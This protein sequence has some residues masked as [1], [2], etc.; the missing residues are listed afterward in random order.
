M[1]NLKKITA[2][3]LLTF[4]IGTVGFAGGPCPPPDPGQIE[5][6]PC[7][8]AQVVTDDLNVAGQ[9]ETPPASNTFDITSAVEEALIAFLLF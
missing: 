9:L 5:T 8:S 6:P 1:T 2:A 3:V 7:A 4:L